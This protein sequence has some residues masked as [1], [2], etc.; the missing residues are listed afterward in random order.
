MKK[1]ILL[2]SAVLGICLL[3]LLTFNL[4]NKK[5]VSDSEL[6]DFSI[7][8]TSSV[9]QIEITDAFSK[10]IKLVKKNG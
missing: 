5:G 4:L 1:I 8:D 2:L 3:T 10:N 9:D 6:I 7:S